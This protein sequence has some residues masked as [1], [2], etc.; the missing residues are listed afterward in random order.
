MLMSTAETDTRR[1]LG[2]VQHWMECLIGNASVTDGRFF[3]NTRCLFMFYDTSVGKQTFC[4]FFTVDGTS[5]NGIRDE[6]FD[7]LVNLA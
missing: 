1:Q 5:E 3:F 6:L 7:W 4:L 2:R